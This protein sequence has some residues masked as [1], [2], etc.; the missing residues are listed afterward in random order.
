ME[1]NNLARA[2]QS[3]DRALALEPGNLAAQALKRTIGDKL[4]EQMQSS[5]QQ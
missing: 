4:A 1:D 2:T 3:V 5:P